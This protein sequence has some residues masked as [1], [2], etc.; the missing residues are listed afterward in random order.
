MLKLL[1]AKKSI[2]VMIVVAVLGWAGY[3]VSNQEVSKVVD[4][5]LTAVPDNVGEKEQAPQEKTQTTNVKEDFNKASAVSDA[6]RTHI[7]YGD[8]T[9]GG[10]LYGTGSPCKSE[11][12]KHWNEDTII[13]EINLIASNDNL[14]W[15]QQRNGYYV[16][17]QNVG[18]VKVRVVKGRKNKS[19]I[20]AYP[21]NTG[22]NPCPANDR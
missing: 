11:F 14:N 17:E 15:E 8:A 13:K 12:P 21:T 18:T 9:G 6:R 20:T 22:R 2:L 16:T 7:L 3:N 4:M 10:H 1:K 5:A 19:V